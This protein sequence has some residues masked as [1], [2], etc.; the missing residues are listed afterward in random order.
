[1]TETS[2]GCAESFFSSICYFICCIRTQFKSEH[3]HFGTLSKEH[4]Q[5]K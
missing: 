4:E 5:I 3:G 1:M 2:F